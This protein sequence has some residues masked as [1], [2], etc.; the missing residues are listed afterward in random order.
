MSEEELRKEAIEAIA[1]GQR[2]RA[3]DILVRLLRADQ[4]NPEYWLWM[5]SLVDTPKERRYCLKRV[6]R[7][8]PGNKSA[9]RGLLSIE[10]LPPPQDLKP[11]PVVRTGQPAIALAKSMMKR[12]F[13]YFSQASW[14][15]RGFFG[16]GFLLFGLLL[17]GIIGLPNRSGGRAVRPAIAPSLS[18]PRPTAT[19][20]PT[21]TPWHLTPTPTFVGPVPL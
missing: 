3:R 16:A 9:Q 6:L 7:L 21:N 10:G 14:R 15:T 1:N 20:L 18:T 5:S 12:L 13:S 17:L 4:S 11:P 19:L 2:Q 8:D